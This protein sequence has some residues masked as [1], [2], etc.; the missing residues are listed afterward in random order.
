MA[1]P[2]ANQHRPMT[3]TRSGE[4]EDRWQWDI[5][6]WLVIALLGLF[7]LLIVTLVSPHRDGQVLKEHL[8]QHDLP[9]SGM[10]R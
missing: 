10:S 6:S 5:V 1:R 7:L 4:P 9:A 8:K 3:T 2:D